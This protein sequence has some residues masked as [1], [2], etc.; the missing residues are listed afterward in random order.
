MS[1]SQVFNFRYE[2]GLE[3]LFVATVPGTYVVKLQAELVFDD[4][5]YPGTTVSESTIEINVGGEAM[6]CTSMNATATP[7]ALGLGGF[8]LGLA[9]VRR[10]RRR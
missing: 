8:L 3:P 1:Y 6:G 9:F 4:D 2:D 5:L 10:R 7:F